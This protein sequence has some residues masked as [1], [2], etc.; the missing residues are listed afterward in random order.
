MRY[1]RYPLFTVYVLASNPF[2]CVLCIADHHIA[3]RRV[4]PAVWS[5]SCPGCDARAFTAMLLDARHCR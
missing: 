5:A 2:V 4:E 1:H 3:S